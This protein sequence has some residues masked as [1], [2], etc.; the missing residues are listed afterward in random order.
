MLL[1]FAG[2]VW[3]VR[4]RKPVFDNSTIFWLL[5]SGL[6]IDIRFCLLLQACAMHM[7]YTCICITHGVGTYWRRGTWVSGATTW[8][9]KLGHHFSSRQLSKSLSPL[10]IEWTFDFW[11]PLL[12]IFAFFLSKSLCFH[13]CFLWFPFFFIHLQSTRYSFSNDVIIFVWRW[14]LFLGKVE[15]F[16][17]CWRRHFSPLWEGAAFRCFPSKGACPD[18][19]DSP[20]FYFWWSKVKQRG[21]LRASPRVC[22]SHSARSPSSPLLLLTLNGW[23]TMFRS[24]SPSS[25]LWQVLLLCNAR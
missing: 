7:Q 13:A 2:E 18:Y 9:E 19:Y 17:L 25:L 5:E 3:H 6:K 21:C 8:F 11:S 23:G 15:G 14:I 20:P 4:W 22:Q 24:T 1:V 16:A 10:L 12:W